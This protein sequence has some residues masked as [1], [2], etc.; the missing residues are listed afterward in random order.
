[1]ML[2]DVAITRCETGNRTGKFERLGLK[3]FALG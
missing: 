3:R 2:A 1:V